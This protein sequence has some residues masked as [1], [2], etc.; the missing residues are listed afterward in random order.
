MKRTGFVAAIVCAAALV[1]APVAS[2]SWAQQDTF[3]WGGSE[4]WNWSAV[5]CPSVAFCMAV[6]SEEGTTTGL[7][8]EARVAGSWN[9]EAPATVPGGSNPGLDSVSCVSA[10]DCWAVGSYFNGTDT[11]VLGESFNG[12]SWTAATLPTPSGVTTAQLNGVSCTSATACVAVG[13]DPSGA[14]SET[15]DGTSWSL[16][17]SNPAGTGSGLSGVS[18]VSAT[19]CVAV[20]SDSSGV[21]AEVWNGSTWTIQPTPNPSGSSPSFT[22]VSCTNASSC[23]AVGYDFAERWNGTS[24]TLQTVPHAPHDTGGGPTLD[25]VSCPQT[26]YCAAAGIYYDDAVETEVVEAWNGTAW[27]VQS[28][29]LDTSNVSSGL[30][31]VSCNDATDCTAAG[32]YQDPTVGDRALAEV[33]ALRWTVQPTAFPDGSTASAL[34]SVSC[35]LAVT[36]CMAVGLSVQSPTETDSIAE[37]WKGALWSLAP[38]ANPSTT[39]LNA[40]SCISA[41]TCTAVGGQLSGSTKFSLAEVFSS[42]GWSIQPTPNPD[43]A[44]QAELYGDSCTSASFCA[45]VG[46][47]RDA[48]GAQWPLAELWNGSNWSVSAVP[49][50][51]PGTGEQLNGVS[52][53][54]PSSCVAVGT[55]TLGNDFEPI[56]EIW[57]GSTWKL[58]TPPLPA[59]ANGGFLS[60]VSCGSSTRCIAVGDYAAGSTVD[61]LSDIWNG[62]KWSF[63]LPLVPPGGGSG[64]PSVLNGVSCW[65]GSMCMSVGQL[66][67]AS[68]V[69][70]ISERFNG[71]GWA[72]VPVPLP[73]GAPTGTL[74]SVSCIRATLCE[75]VGSYNF[76]TTTMLAENY[77]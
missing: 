12:T 65:A 75:A 62:T 49:P 30:S 60:G 56:S 54:S 19:D 48:T 16:L 27:H 13:T 15:W 63:G 51:N 46:E 55:Y 18:C 40:V 31:G 36:S 64:H 32:F 4:Q 69:T 67:G 9:A 24:W 34:V 50:R 68:G 53:T 11:V 39:T 1:L 44:Q 35:P 72:L 7:I 28:A 26:N 14:F 21:L 73:Q 70:P 29:P 43:G 23:T 47:Y 6:G 57:N 66:D 58:M 37:G 8:A 61:P 5:S 33:E 74:D 2:A 59:V 45:A 71:A 3:N 20:G 22:G 77:S 10:S 17:G 52:C 76:N 38:P 25:G 41:T 42:S